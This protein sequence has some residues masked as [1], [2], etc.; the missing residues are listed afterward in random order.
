MRALLSARIGADFNRLWT[1]SAISNIG[2]GV[3]MAAGPL[4]VASISDNP[5]L[6]AGAVFA[7]QLPCLLI[8]LISGAWVD[9]VDRRTTVVVVDLLRAAALAVLTVTITA[10]TVTIPI[11]YLVVFLLGVGETLAD[12]AMGAMIPAIVAPEHLAAANARLG[13]TFSI[14]NQF[15]AKPL[16]TWLFV[17]SA[18]LPFGLDALTFAACAALIA[19]VRPVP[20]SQNHERTSLRREIGA[21]IRWL[22]DHRLLRTTAITMGVGNIAFCAAFAV[23]VV[24]CRDR[25]GLSE[26]GYGVLLTAFAAG[27]LLGA[28]VAARLSRRF[29]NPTLLRAG[30]IIE[31]GVHLT[32]AVTTS[33]W[34]AA[35]VLTV[36]SVHTMVWGVITATIG[37][38]TVP[39]HFRGRVS[40]VYFLLQTGGAALGSLLG[41]ILAGVWSITTPFW[42]AAVA[43]VLITVCAWRPLGE[44]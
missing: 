5:S 38:R 25:L 36:F 15:L 6:V 43:M 32:L 10:D 18:A 8:G 26:V 30:L 31:V 34:T 28:G 42:I 41:G 40:S 12:N 27:G 24:Y 23:F 33:P 35:A 1:A 16:G 11:V 3:T 21:G 22:W 37:Q 44:A 9:R 2:D 14:G 4:L 20:P 17:I 13:A 19:G 29:G 39:D 7:Q